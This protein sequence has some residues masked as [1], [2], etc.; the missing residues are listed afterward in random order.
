MRL[1]KNNFATRT[2]RFIDKKGLILN[3]QLTSDFRAELIE[4]N[5]LFGSRKLTKEYAT[6]S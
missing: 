5:D 1:I 2:I 3:G 4:S 6:V